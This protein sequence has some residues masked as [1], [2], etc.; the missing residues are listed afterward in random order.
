MFFSVPSKFAKAKNVVNQEFDKN[1]SDPQV[2]LTLVDD[3]PIWTKWN[4]PWAKLMKSG[5]NVASAGD[6]V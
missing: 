2:F 5:K 3:Y 4:T 1:Q 6:I